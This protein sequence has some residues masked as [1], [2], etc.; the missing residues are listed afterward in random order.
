[1]SRKTFD[2]C[3]HH[4]LVASPLSRNLD[5]RFQRWC[6]PLPHGQKR[7]T[8]NSQID[9]NASKPHGPFNQ[10]FWTFSGME[11]LRLQQQQHHACKGIIAFAMRRS[12][13]Q[14]I[15]SSAP[16]VFRWSISRSR[17]VSRNET[18]SK[19]GHK[20]LFHVPRAAGTTPSTAA[21]IPRIWAFKYFEARPV[22][23]KL[24]PYT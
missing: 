2:S 23:A 7:V 13:S 20:L 21:C 10:P 12:I 22:S 11:L 17:R 8:S 24:K 15:N 5:K 3:R 1:L 4:P 9:Q 14:G 19:S 18:K 6:R 16:H